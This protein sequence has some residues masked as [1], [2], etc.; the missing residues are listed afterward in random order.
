MKHSQLRIDILC[1]LYCA[2]LADTHSVWGKFQRRGCEDTGRLC[3]ARR[4]QRIG[5]ILDADTGCLSAEPLPYEHSGRY[6]REAIM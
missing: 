3:T 2:I 4:A 6:L 5:Y 1:R